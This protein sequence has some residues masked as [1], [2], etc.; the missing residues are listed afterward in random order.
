VQNI[1]LLKSLRILSRHEIH[2]ESISIRILTHAETVAESG[3]MDRGLDDEIK[4]LS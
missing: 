2:W 3:I 4:K 1:L